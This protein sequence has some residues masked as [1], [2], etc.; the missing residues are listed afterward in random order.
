HH[1]DAHRDVVHGGRAGVQPRRAR[2]DLRGGAGVPGEE[3]LEGGRQRRGHRRAALLR[4]R[5]DPPGPLGLPRPQ[6]P[7]QVQDPGGLPRVLLGTEGRADP[8]RLRGRQPRELQLPPGAPLRRVGRAEHL[9][10]RRGGGR[11][12]L[13]EDG[14]AR[15]QHARLEPEDAPVQQRRAP[16]R[17]PH[18]GGRRGPDEG[19]E[20]RSDGR[21]DLARL[22]EGRP[23]PRRRGRPGEEEAVLRGGGRVEH[24]RE[25]GERGAPGDAPAGA[26]VRG[27]PARQVRGGGLPR[28]PPA[29]GGDERADGGVDSLART[30]RFLSLDKCLPRRRHIQVVHV[31][32]SSSR[33]VGHPGEMVRR[34]P[35]LEYDPSWLA[36]LRRTHP[37]TVRARGAVPA[38]DVGPATGGEVEEVT[39]RLGEARASDRDGDDDDGDSGGSVGAACPEMSPLAIPENFVRTVPP[40][41]ASGGDPGRPTGPPR[42]MVG[43]PQTDALLGALGLDHVVTV[44]FDRAGMRRR[45]E[46]EEEERS[47]GRGGGGGTIQLTQILMDLREDDDKM[48]IAMPSDLTN[49]QRIF[50]HELAKQLGQKSKSSGKG[51][52][53]RI[54]VR[55]VQSGNSGG[56]MGTY[57]GYVFS[58]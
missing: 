3:P 27:A 57:R 31:E 42:G 25:R 18:E 28:G 32:P 43:N 20:R 36:V 8:D 55:K 49:T 24:A 34:G 50:C 12:A 54:R 16:E 9:L 2:L 30:T 5:A 11:P 44:P 46:E 22:A 14:G 58:S 23:P 15:G 33:P 7:G 39:R 17:V 35:W 40:F 10:P 19:P 37:L 51:E 53:R 21:H 38:P 26:L 41:D 45:R 56:M 52:E 1:R 13:Q 48:E 4:R 6:R 29:D 47:R